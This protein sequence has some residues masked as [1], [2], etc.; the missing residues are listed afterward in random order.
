[1]R[2]NWCIGYSDRFTVAVWVGNLEGDPMRAVS[3]TTGAAPV[4]RDM[5]IALHQGQP[6]RQPARPGNV[7]ATQVSFSTAREPARPEWFLAGTQQA[8]MAEAPAFARRPR[9]LNPASG[10]VYARDPDIPAGRQSIGVSIAGNAADLR[11]T[12][13]G[14]PLATQADGAQLPL[15]RGSHLLALVDAGGRTIDQ[16]RFTVR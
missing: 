2:D 15:L 9:I 8:R 16:V 13:D 7:V 11:L 3:G 14:R 10:A 5:M 1:M 4:W 6:G 12:L